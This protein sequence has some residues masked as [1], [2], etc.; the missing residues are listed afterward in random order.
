MQQLVQQVA[1]HQASQDP[2]NRRL[3]QKNRIVM[4]RPVETFP[5]VQKQHVSPR[6]HC[7]NKHNHKRHGD[8]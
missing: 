8:N 1:P 3:A 6:I 2:R 7:H 4:Q 5:D